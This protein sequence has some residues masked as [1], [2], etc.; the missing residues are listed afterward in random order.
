MPGIH[1]VLEDV[2]Q[3]AGNFRKQR[4]T[5][6]GPTYRPACAPQCTGAPR[7]RAAGYGS[8]RMPEYSRRNCRCSDA[9]CRKIST[10]VLVRRT[11]SLSS[12]FV[13]ASAPDCAA[14]SDKSAYRRCTIVSNFTSALDASIPRDRGTDIRPA[15]G[16]RRSAGSAACT[17]L[18][19]KINQHVHAEDHVEA[20][21]VDGLRQVH[22]RKRNQVPQRGFTMN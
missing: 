19:G 2:R 8:C 21:H 9:S 5:V 20:A 1:R 15:P 11:H 4:E 10:N 7:P 17:A 6:R 12:A 18:F 14:A 16:I 3:L 13:P 22:R